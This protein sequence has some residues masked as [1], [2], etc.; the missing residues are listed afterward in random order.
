MST[1][2]PAVDRQTD[3]W[4]MILLMLF[5]V[6][7]RAPIAARSTASLC[8]DVDNYRELAENLRVH[9]T[10]GPRPDEPSAYRPPLYPLLLV[11]V[12]RDRADDFTSLVVLHVVIG[13]AAVWLTAVAGELWGLGRARFVAAVLVACDP[14]LLKQSTVVMTET[15]ATAI[16]ALALVALTLVTRRPTLGRVIGAGAVLGLSVLCRPAFLVFAVAAL[17]TFVWLMPCAKDGLRVTALITVAL[18]VTLAPWTI[19][20]WVQ[21][22]RPIV[23]TTHGGFTLALANNPE[24]YAHLRAHL[25]NRG[26]PSAITGPASCSSMRTRRRKSWRTI[27]SVTSWRGKQSMMSRGCSCA[28][29]LSPVAVVGGVTAGATGARSA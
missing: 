2:A 28:L 4:L 12:V 5:A 24:F 6:L 8:A 23:T 19:R 21:F 29:R 3:R 22:G 15:L 13:L 11:P 17:P 9:G 27:E 7:V 1:N 10:C 14:I 16:A 25:Q 26:M 20:N 18:A